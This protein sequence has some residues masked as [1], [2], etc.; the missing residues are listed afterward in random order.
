VETRRRRLAKEVT[1]RRRL[2]EKRNVAAGFNVALYAPNCAP[3]ETRG[4]L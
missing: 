4:S 3:G 1:S 2:I